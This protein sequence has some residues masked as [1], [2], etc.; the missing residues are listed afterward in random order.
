VPLLLLGIPRGLSSI[1]W[2]VTASLL[3][4]AAAWVKRYLIVV[5]TLIHPFLPVQEVPTAW[6]SYF[7][8]LVEWSVTLGTFAGFLLVYTLVSRLFPIVSVWETV[9]GLKEAGAEKVG[10]DPALAKDSGVCGPS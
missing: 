5:P 8:S 4:V 10:L 2:V 9:E 7:P 6:S 3:V 1:R